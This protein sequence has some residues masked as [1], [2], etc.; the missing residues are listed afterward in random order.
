MTAAMM[1][2]RNTPLSS[3]IAALALVAGLAST[4]CTL[5]REPSE[6]S[7][8]TDAPVLSLFGDVLLPPDVKADVS[9]T[10][11]QQ[12]QAAR[13][14]LAVVRSEGLDDEQAL[15]W[16]GRRLAYEVRYR[17]AVAVFS[18]GLAEHDAS[19]RL[20]RHRGHRYISMRAFDRAVQDLS[21]AAGLAFGV[22]DQIEP[23]GAPNAAGIPTSTDQSNIYYHL[24]LAHYLRGDFGQALQAYE[25]G[26]VFS[27]VN[28][29]M[30][31]A[32]SW[33]TW[34]AIQRSL[35]EAGVP[36]GREDAATHDRIHALLEPIHADMEILENHAYLDLLLLALG[37]LSVADARGNDAAGIQDSTRAYGIAAFQLARGEREAGLEQCERIVTGS[38]WMAFGHIAAEAELWRARHK[39]AGGD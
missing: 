39:P 38:W 17:D 12:T 19:Y 31:V 7:T 3:S 37:E 32:T 26:L 5:H 35:R 10:R 6:S 30:L 24:G 23:D 1:T 36:F 34:L 18:E 8:R 4:A 16:L 25:Q 14:E 33:W 28:N 20:Y 11:I 15:I 22:E 21:H 9:A 13:V 29:D 27:R 2:H